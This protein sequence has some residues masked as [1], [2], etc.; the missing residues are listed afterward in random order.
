M[1]FKSLFFSVFIGAMLL[2]GAILLNNKRPAVEKN[3]PSSQAVRATGKCAQCHR[4][5]TPAV[6]HQFEMSRHAKKGITCLDC[7]RVVEGQTSKAHRGFTITTQITSKNCAQCHKTEHEQFMR[8][9]HAAPAW[10]AVAG[11]KAFTPKQLAFAEK[12]HKGAVDRAANKLAQLEGPGAITKGCEGC[13]NIGKPNKDGSIGTCTQCHSR[14]STSVALARH[15]ETCGQCH[16][17]PDHS[18]LEIFKESKHGALFAAQKNLMKL[19]ARPK[20]LTTKDMSV[21]TCATCHM[22]GLE[23][24]KVTH[25]VT[26]RLS[27]YLFAPVSKK[28]P[29]YQRNQ[30]EMKELCKKCH[31]TS[32]VERFYKEAEVVVHSTNQKVKEERKIIQ[33]L[34]KKGLLTPQPFDEPIEFL[35]FDF[36]HYYGRTAKHAAFMGGADFVQWHGNYELLHLFVKIKKMAQQIEQNAARKKSNA[37]LKKTN[38]P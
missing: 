26:E 20:T 28:R 2:I 33:R 14:H 18:Q 19:H 27:W 34:R 31:T 6:V 5:E 4:R 29:G 16:M 8:S 15:P 3:Q 37:A 24:M 21:P 36:W 32:H 30:H 11:R 1:Q 10:A 7:H 17:G 23:G 35:H 38:K 12:Y 25:D 9:R 13:H 22:S